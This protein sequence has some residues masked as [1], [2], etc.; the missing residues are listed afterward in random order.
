MS[1]KMQLDF[2]EEV[3]EAKASNRAT[4]ALESTVIAHGLKFPENFETAL[5][6]ENEIRS[7]GAIP[8][9]IAVICGR[10][11]VGLDKEE[12]MQLSEN[13]NIR[14]VSKRDLPICTARKQ[15]GA[16]TV[17]AT[18]L[19]AYQAGIKVFA[20]GGIG[21][22]HLGFPA[23]ISADLPT[24]AETPIT[25]VC[26]GPKSILDL[27]ATREWLETHGIPIIGYKC[28][29]MPSFFSSKSGLKVDEAVDSIEEIVEIIRLRDELEMKSAC[30]I[31]NPV[32]PDFEIDFEEQKSYLN[33]ALELAR[34]QNVN[35]KYLT[36]FLLKK[37]SE[38]SQNKTLQANI[39]LL[40]N[41]SKLAA[42]ISLELA[43]AL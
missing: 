12:L 40:K 14:K 5:E 1:L 4:V 43:K 6:M 20:T 15:T 32:P 13:Q 25:V 33:C 34:K 18:S 36:P 24:L 26:S 27:V 29:E 35:G 8:A 37:M 9:T 23:D 39:A 2:S 22:V 30:L 17:S 41:N 19:I 38:V 28:E 31:M 11:K 3:S 21:G 16:T 7:L 42:M 10:I